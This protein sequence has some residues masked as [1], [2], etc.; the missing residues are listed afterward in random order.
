MTTPSPPMTRDR[1]R[2]LAVTSLVLGLA[3]VPTL[4]LCGAGLPLAV[5]AIVI[6]II[7]LAKG[8][9]RVPAVLGILASVLTLVIC[10]WLVGK[11][12]KCGDGSRY[13]DERARRLCI[14]H[15][16]PFTRAGQ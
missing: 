7:A 10:G 3:S 15:E 16:F 1:G 12:A 4:V 14:E 8:Q 2:T 5:A 9:G 6:G 13:P 11:A